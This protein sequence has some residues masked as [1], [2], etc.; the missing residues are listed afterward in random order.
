MILSFVLFLGL[1]LSCRM[2]FKSVSVIFPGVM[3]VAFVTGDRDLDI[4]GDEH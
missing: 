4:G 2:L 1:M 3:E